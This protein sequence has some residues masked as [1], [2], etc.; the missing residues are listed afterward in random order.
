MSK[1]DKILLVISLFIILS[2]IGVLLFDKFSKN[3]DDSS[4][5]IAEDNIISVE[6][7]D[8]LYETEEYH[9]DEIIGYEEEIEQDIQEVKSYSNVLEIPQCNILTYIYD[10]T[11][12]QSLTYGVGHYSQTVEVGA[13]GNCAIAGHSSSVYNCILNNVKDLNIYDSFNVYDK[14]GTKHVYYVLSK[15]VVNPEDTYVLDSKDFEHSQ[16]TITTCTNEGKQRLIIEGVEL[17]DEELSEY[18]KSADELKYNDLKAIL[19]EYEVSSILGYL[20]SKESI[21]PKYYYLNIVKS[22][23]YRPTIAEGLYGNIINGGI[24]YDITKN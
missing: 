15:Y 2:G 18:K 4:K 5:K 12:K 19:D 17:T 11:S 20:N 13:L 9:L 6:K 3:F 14:A 24:Q 8:S 1:R 23:K 22:N 16:F 10:D 7:D 21:E